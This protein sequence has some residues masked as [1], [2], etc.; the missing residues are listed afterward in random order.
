MFKGRRTYYLVF[1]I[2]SLFLFAGCSTENKSEKYGE[3]FSLG[4][5]MDYRSFVFEVINPTR[6]PYPV[7]INELYGYTVNKQSSHVESV[8]EAI[9]QAAKPFTE[10]LGAVKLNNKWGYI[11]LK[12]G[13]KTYEFAIPN[14]KLIKTDGKIID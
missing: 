11:T 1:I 6:T 3:L 14:R 8:T 5:G 2:F 10:Q 4:E 9:F 12:E 7:K 13:Y